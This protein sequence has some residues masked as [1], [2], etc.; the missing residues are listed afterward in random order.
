MSEKTPLIILI[1]DLAKKDKVKP[2]ESPGLWTREIDQEWT[3]KLNPHGTQVEKVPPYTAAVYFNG[4]PAGLIDPGGG[5][6]AA[7]DTANEEALAKA[8]ERE[9]RG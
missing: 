2:Y 5:I 7:G 4:W 8:I 3:I 1:A 9:L 6:I